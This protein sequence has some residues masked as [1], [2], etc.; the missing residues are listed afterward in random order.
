[1]VAMGLRTVVI[2]LFD[3]VQSLDVTGPLEV[4]TGAA[5]WL[6]GQDGRAADGTPG[7]LE[8]VDE[9]FAVRAA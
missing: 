5:R 7:G 1:M 6:D 9:P 8:L 2:A 4:F 3:D